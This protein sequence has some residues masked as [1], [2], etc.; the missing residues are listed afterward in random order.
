MGSCSFQRKIQNFTYNMTVFGKAI[1]ATVKQSTTNSVFHGLA[2]IYTH[3][4]NLNAVAIT[5][6]KP[7]WEGT[8]LQHARP[9]HSCKLFYYHSTSPSVSF[10]Q[11]CCFTHLKWGPLSENTSLET[12]CCWQWCL[13]SY[14]DTSSWYFKKLHMPWH[15][16]LCLGLTGMVLGKVSPT[17]ASVL[18][19]WQK[20]P[21]S[22]GVS[23][24]DM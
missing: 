16:Q 14:T 5:L 13:R 12:L 3:W 17:T 2:Y 20:P 7:A 21:I 23:F 18:W 6:Q 22:T 19:N 10:G 1:L 11:K 9:R 8:M 15:R 4:D 24:T